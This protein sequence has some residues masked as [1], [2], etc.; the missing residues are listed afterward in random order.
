MEH[1]F[2]EDGYYLLDPM[3]GS[4]EAQTSQQNFPPPENEGETFEAALFALGIIGLIMYHGNAITHLYTRDEVGNRKIN[5][6]S[7]QM[8]IERVQEL[9]LRNNLAIL[10]HNHPVFRRNFAVNRHFKH[11]EPIFSSP[12]SFKISCST[13]H[14][15]PNEHQL[16]T[17]PPLSPHAEE[18]TKSKKP[19]VCIRFNNKLVQSADN[20][21]SSS[22]VSTPKASS[23]ML[24]LKMADNSIPTTPKARNTV[25]VSSGRVQTLGTPEGRKRRDC[26]ST[27]K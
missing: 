15:T 18:R 13:N 10:T 9:T 27:I 20:L 22:L 7:L 19:K 25:T 8:W 21:H 17:T 24:I 1:I 14:H 16:L 6:A 4:T 3:M 23:N 11:S 5:Q 26:F 2:I 12:Q